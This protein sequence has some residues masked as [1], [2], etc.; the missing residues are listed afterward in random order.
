MTQDYTKTVGGADAWL[1]RQQACAM[2]GVSESTWLTWQRNGRVTCGKRHRR[3]GDGHTC[4]LYPKAELQRLRDQIEQI[5]KPYA[6]PQR[7][8]VWRVPL[9]G[10]TTQR[11]ALID[12]QDLPIVQGK[13]WNWSERSDGTGGIVILARPQKPLH[14]LILGLTDKAARVSFAN[15]DPLDCRRENLLVR[16][17]ADV[18]HASRPARTRNGKV[19]ASTFKGVAFDKRSGK[20]GATIRRGEV[21]TGI[22]EFDDERAAAEAYDDCVRVWF[23]EGAYL[24]FP[25]RTCSDEKR[26]WAQGVLERAIKRL[27]RRG[28]RVRKLERLLKREARAMKSELA[29]KP[30]LRPAPVEEAAVDGPMMVEPAIGRREA[31]KLL[32]VPRK[33]WRRWEKRGWLTFGRSVDGRRVYLV[34]GI[35]RLLEAC[36][37]L[38]PPYADPQRANVW[39]VPLAGRRVRIEAVIDASSLPLLEGGWCMMS[40]MRAETG[41]DAY[42]AVFSPAS[43]EHRPLRRLVA[44]VTD[45]ALL[46]GHRNDDPLDC[47]RANL[48]VQTEAQRSYRKRKIQSV[49]GQPTTS[50]FKGVSWSKGGKKW[51]AMIH[52]GGTAHYLGLHEREDNAALAYD[53]AARELFGEHAR[54]NF[55]DG[56]DAWIDQEAAQRQDDGA[57]TEQREAA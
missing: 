29:S 20:W 34:A 49:N 24:N 32:G 44:G 57:S 3:P 50:Q 25:E 28:R 9:T 2:F 52:C 53:R 36:G 33:M 35:K 4:V 30:E 39:H 8:A 12:E 38:R 7:P 11:E 22:G 42:V 55:P 10:Y 19:C 41:A 14:R 45:E 56:I 1:T 16:T 15:G 37:R 18:A 27:R 21:E 17:Q 5:G 6:D 23:G 47:R 48:V 43:K 31:R 26:I 40:G 13:K 54:P 46:V 51:M